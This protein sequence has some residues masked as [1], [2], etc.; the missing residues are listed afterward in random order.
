MNIGSNFDTGIFSNVMLFIALMLYLHLLTV[1]IFNLKKSTMNLKKLIA[2]L[3]VTM[4][5]SLV[6]PAF[7]GNE[8]PV[9]TERTT[10][11]E[12]AQLLINRLKEIK[13]MDKSMLTSSEKKALRK[14]LRAMKKEAKKETKGVY[15]SVGAII[16]IILLLILLL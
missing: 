14:E 2:V 6:M 4:S 7:A 3:L 9:A 15:L 10:N 11:N 8:T 5:T 13:E 16:I 1:I 12:H